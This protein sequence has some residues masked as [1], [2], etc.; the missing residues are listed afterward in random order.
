MNLL[1]NACKFTSDGLITVKAWVCDQEETQKLKQK[2]VS[3][4]KE[5]RRLKT[6]EAN[7]P[8]KLDVGE[9]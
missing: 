6:I 7:D 5:R 2:E 4:A 9:K 3:S 1:S 8:T